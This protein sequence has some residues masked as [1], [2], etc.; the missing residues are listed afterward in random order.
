MKKIRS[1]IYKNSLVL[2]IFLVLLISIL[3]VT[4]LIVYSSMRMSSQLFMDT[5]SITNTKVMNQINDRFYTFSNS[6]ISASMATENNGVIKQ[7]LQQE[8]NSSLEK[9][10][11]YYT[12]GQEMDKLQAHVYDAATIV[13]LTNNND[14]FNTNFGV[15]DVDARILANSEVKR[16][17]EES[18]NKI[19]FFYED[20][21]L[22][23]NQPMIITGKTLEERSTQTTYGYFFT[24]IK[25]RDL[26]N[27]YQDYTSEGNNILLLT[28]NGK[29]ISS[30]LRDKIGKN[31]EELL[32]HVLDYEKSNQEYKSIRVFDQNYTILAEYVPSLHIY[33][34]N[35][36]DQE[37]LAQNLID[38]NQTVI[39]SVTVA[40]VALIL[41]FFI[42][43]RM[44]SSMSDLVYQISDMARYQFNKPLKVSGGY[45]TRKTAEAFNYMLNE[46]QDYVK[47]LID[48][49]E[50][51]R[52]S[53]L[54][55]LQH[56]INPHFI[57][58]TLTSIKFMMNQDKK[59]EAIKTI[60]SF[61]VL[62]QNTISNLDEIITVEQEVQNLK[63]YVQ[64]MQ[65]RYSNKIKV[66]YFLSPTSL[67]LYVP[68]LVL[69]PFMENAFFHAFT[70]KKEGH[71]HIFIAEKEDT[72]VCEMID[73]GEGMEKSTTTTNVPKKKNQ[74][75]SGIGVKN[76]HE[77]IQ[78]L[79]G[80]RYGV[81]MTSETDKGTKVEIRL[82]IQKKET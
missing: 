4:I 82:P 67:E 51:Q 49:Q 28:P 12:I 53:E 34:V 1:I 78:L 66:H 24:A 2:K 16:K 19:Q 26:R 35:L 48:T 14:T 54:K 20:S 7:H 76:V 41:A 81:K 3:S 57:Y 9:H 42:V 64:I 25:E 68:K 74:L 32:Q 55:A 65:T 59:E 11:F 17:V 38:T 80:M 73:D 10:E 40:I 72:L 21:E 50:K 79:Y 36:I 31:S 23:N 8:Y 58:N 15:W 39:I 46:L 70:Q 6:I 60:E 29:I 22:T 52:K 62:L 44:T 13:L 5:F 47:I 63:N 45:E 27:F 71:I 43:R 37:L 77:R 56:Q 33:I 18:D 30:N 69:Q 61:I 75:F